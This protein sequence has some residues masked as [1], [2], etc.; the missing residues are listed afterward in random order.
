MLNE[1][2]QLYFYVEN[3]EIYVRILVDL[4]FV[5]MMSLV[6]LYIEVWYLKC[7]LSGIYYCVFFNVFIY[8]WGFLK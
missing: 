7:V 6:F 5:Q 3:V 8:L 2:K 1:L 4:V